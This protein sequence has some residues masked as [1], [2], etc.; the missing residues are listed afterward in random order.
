M[1]L[2]ILITLAVAFA[3]ACIATAQGMPGVVVTGT[4][5]YAPTPDGGIQAIDVGKGTILWTNRDAQ[6]PLAA[7]SGKLVAMGGF[8]KD[9]YSTIS[10]ID[11]DTGTT[12]SRVGPVSFTSWVKPRMDFRRNPDDSFRIWVPS[13]NSGGAVVLWKAERWPPLDIRHLNA[14]QQKEFASGR[15][16]IEFATNSVQSR[17]VPVQATPGP[18]APPDKSLPLLRGEYAISSMDVYSTGLTVA[19]IQKGRELYVECFADRLLRWSQQI[20]KK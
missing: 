15:I 12:L 9:N 6:W 13:L 20:V 14:P 16:T 8:G 7:A 18:Y 3:A 11:R 19:L 4:A 10:F 2:R 5:V 17:L 1:P